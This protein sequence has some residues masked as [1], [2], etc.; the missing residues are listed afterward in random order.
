MER[1]HSDG[2]ER[3]LEDNI[4]MIL[5]AGYDGI[6]ADWR[7]RDTVRR[8]HGLITLDLLD[9]FPATQLVADLSHYVV[10]QE[11]TLPVAEA[12]QRHIRRILDRSG[13]FH[14]RVASSE[15]V[16]VEI[17][18]PRHKPWL[19]LFLDWWA[20]GLQE[21][22]RPVGAQR[23]P[24]HHLRVGAETLRDRRVGRQRPH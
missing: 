12:S 22:A 21:L 8:M 20:Y 14:G 9:S 15:Q 3:S 2:F 4:G 19:E 11:L 18:F 24:R 10:G 1:R 5:D 13:A 6:A 16:Q 7:D 17:S 23:H